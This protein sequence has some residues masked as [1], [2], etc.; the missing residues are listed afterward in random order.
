MFEE[1]YLTGDEL[2][3]RHPDILTVPNG[4]AL[5][6][7]AWGPFLRAVDKLILLAEA[8]S[9]ECTHELHKLIATAGSVSQNLEGRQS[10]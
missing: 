4:D 10:V 5:A 2:K 3:T 9:N 1:L 7:Q 6:A 8:D